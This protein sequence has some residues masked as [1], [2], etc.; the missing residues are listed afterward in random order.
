MVHEVKKKKGYISRH[1]NDLDLPDM[2][3]HCVAHKASTLETP[4]AEPLLT[5]LNGDKAV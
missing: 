4:S 2:L 3:P 1:K 5:N